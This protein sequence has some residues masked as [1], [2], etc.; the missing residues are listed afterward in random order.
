MLRRSALA[1]LEVRSDLGEDNDLSEKLRRAWRLLSPLDLVAVHYGVP[2]TLGGV[3]RRFHRDGV[4]VRALLRVYSGARQLGHVARMVPLPLVAVA[5]AAAAL[6]WHAVAGASAALLG[7]Y[8]AAFLWASRNVPARPADR[9][10]GAALFTLGNLA[11][12]VGY[13]QEAL[14]RPS[15]LMQEPGRPAR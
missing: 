15:D 14:R 13:A 11:F 2:T 7:A 5:V 6:E 1:G 9:L 12:G 4:R 3:L 8:V 10:C